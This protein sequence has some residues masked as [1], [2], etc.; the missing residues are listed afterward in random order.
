MFKRNVSIRVK[1]LMTLL[2]LFLLPSATAAEIDNCCF[3]DRQCRTNYDWVSGY[4]ALQNNH[5]AAPS[6]QQQQSTSSQPQASAPTVINNCCFIGWQCAT[7]EEWTSGYWAFQNNL[8]GTPIGSKSQS[9]SRGIATAAID[10]LT[11]TGKRVEGHRQLLFHRLAVRDRR[12][13]GGWLLGVSEQSMRRAN[14]L[15]IAVTIVEYCNGRGQQ[16]LFHRLAV[17]RR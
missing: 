8:C 11:T 9:Q 1:L 4:Y 10:I 6:Q 12:R 15:T 13:M 17:R 3:V 5:C 7:D 16:L 14:W 2:A